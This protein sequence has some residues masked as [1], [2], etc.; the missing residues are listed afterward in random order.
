MPD[1]S[2]SVSARYRVI[3]DKDYADSFGER[4]AF[5]LDVLVG[6]SESPKWLPS[7]YLYD[8]RGSELFYRITQL[9][10]YY[11]TGCELEI[12]QR[13]GRA[14]V[15]HLGDRPFNL[16]ELGAG[17]G[18]KTIALLKQ[19][20][21]MDLDFHYVPIDISELAM[22]RLVNDIR[23][24]LPDVRTEGL[25][26]DYFNGLKWLNNRYSRQNFVIFLGSSIGNFLRA[27]AR[28]FLRNVWNCL[29]HNDLTLTGFDLKKDIELL[30]LAYNDSQGITSE[31]NLNYLERINREL[32]GQFDIS[33]FR[34]YGTYDVF[35]G[36]M[37]SYLVSLEPQTVFI[38]S[39]GRSFTFEAWEPIHIENSYKYLKAE[40][41]ELAHLT[42][43]EVKRHYIDSREY[44]ID[45]VWKVV[46]HNS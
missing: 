16:V 40:I 10:E 21:E 5:A 11:V 43:F 32:G 22:A 23:E 44:F 8:D 36:G 30:L 39:I 31:F 45:S 2:Q 12:I 9:P 34:H 28:Q 6:L 14:M 29:N 15:S 24:Q 46:K 17:Y 19:F 38:E 35:A 1:Q 7:K 18:S 33:R 27:E 13:D 25:V 37:K 20:L 26:S 41:D 4:D 3:T 42:G